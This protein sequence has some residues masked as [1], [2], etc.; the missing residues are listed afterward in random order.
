M[1]AVAVESTAGEGTPVSL[2]WHART[3]TPANAADSPL[4]L[5]TTLDRT[6]VSEGDTVRVTAVLTNATAQPVGMAMAIVGLP[7]GLRL[8]PDFKQL[9]ALTE[10]PAAGEPRASH[11]EVTPREVVFYRRGLAANESVTLAFDAVAETPGT[12]RGPAS[13]AYP[14]YA[15]EFKHWATPLGVSVK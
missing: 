8:P 11:F 10:R 4:T 14:Y 1:T 15:P 7:A 13:R 6:E 9:K 5:T 12:S 3:A 2:T